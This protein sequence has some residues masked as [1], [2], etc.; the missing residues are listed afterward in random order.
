[1]TH[2]DRKNSKQTI[3]SQTVSGH[4]AKSNHQDQDHV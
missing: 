1:M 2:I 3:L 4:N